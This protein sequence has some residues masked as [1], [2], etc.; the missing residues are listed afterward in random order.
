MV[1]GVEVRAALEGF[2]TCAAGFG[3]DAD[4]AEGAGSAFCAVDGR[5]FCAGFVEGRDFWAEEAVFETDEGAEG[6]TAVFCCE[7][8]TGPSAD[9]DLLIPSP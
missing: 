3:V 9:I 7:L 2:D 5:A 8:D 4:F 1:L 6:F